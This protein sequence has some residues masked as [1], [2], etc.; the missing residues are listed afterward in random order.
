MHN[1]CGSPA[2]RQLQAQLDRALHG[3]LRSRKDDF[4]PAAEYIKRA[5][6]AHYKEIHTKVG[7]TVSPWGDWRSTMS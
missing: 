7:H 5:G 3:R 4:L 1:L 2:L 6:V